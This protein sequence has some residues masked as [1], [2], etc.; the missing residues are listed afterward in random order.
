MLRSIMV[1][2]VRNGLLLC[3]VRSQV[4]PCRFCGAPDGDG[5]LFW[6][7]TLPPLV[8]IRENPEFH[9]LIRMDKGH[10][11]RCLLGHGW[12]PLLSGV[13]GASPWAASASESAG[14]LLEAALGCYSSG[15]VAEW[16]P[17]DGNDGVVVSSL[18]LDHP[19]VWSDA[20]LVLDQVTGV[21]SSGAG[22]LAH[23][24]VDFWSD[25]RWCYVDHVRHEV[26]SCRGFCSVP[27]RLQSVQR[28]ER[29]GVI[30]AL[31]SSGAVHLGVDNLGVVRHVGRLLGGNH[32]SVPFEL[33]KDG[34]LLLLLDRMLHLRGLDTV[35]I[36][37]VEGHADEGMVPDGQVR[38]VDR[39]CTDVADEAADFGRKRVGAAVIDARRNLSGGCGRW[40]PVIL[41]L[42]RF[43]I[44]ISRAVVNHDGRDGAARDPLFW[45]AG[46]P[47][48]RRRL[49]HAVRDQAFLPGP[50][51]T[52]DS[53]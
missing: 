29:W 43:F 42:H 49:V 36:T 6:E 46:A 41:N 52:W 4:L 31:Q 35:R 48:K 39:I 24:S 11:P 10:W 37:K 22:F 19:N 45:S 7:S 5:H 38:E 30:F 21:S 33:V 25:R 9:D 12:L 23:Q 13:N 40:Y 27:G 15:M 2:G 51:G 16:S 3:R 34:D 8:E 53:D 1:W 18:V 17:P 47:P 20:G 14:Y 26:Q 32:G 44:A 50:P 28:A